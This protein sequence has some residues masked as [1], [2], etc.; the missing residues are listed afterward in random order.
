MSLKRNSLVLLLLLLLLVLGAG[1]FSYSYFLPRYIER[2]ILPDIGRRLSSS[3][4]GQVRGIGFSA[5]DFGDIVLGDSPNPAVTIGSIHAEYSVPDLLAKKMGQVT[6]NGLSLHMEVADGR[7]IMPGIDLEKLAAP[8]TSALGTEAK[9]SG[10]DLP[11]AVG[12]FQVKSGLLHI[13]YDGER[14]LLPFDLSLDS[15]DPGSGLPVYNLSLLLMPMGEEILLAGS[16]DLTGN[17]STFTLAADSLHLDR[18]AK[19]TGIDS[20]N[21]TL[22]KASIR[23]EAAIGLFP[24]AI[25]SASLAIDPDVLHFGKTPV[26]FAPAPDGSH[27]I[28][29]ELKNI[30]EQ[31][32][33]KMQGFISSPLAASLELNG[34]VTREPDNVLGSGNMII[35][36]TAAK[37]AET[38]GGPLPML[39]NNAE[40]RGDF[41]LAYN[42][43]G[44]WRAELKSPGQKQ[45]TGQPR[46]LQVRYDTV[47]LQAGM[48]AFA[49]LGHGSGGTTE[50]QVTIALPRIQA[51]YGDMEINVPGA[52]LQA[53]YTQDY[54]LGQD[55]TSSTVLRLELGSTKLQQKGLNVKADF[56]LQGK[57]ASQLR[58]NVKTQRAEG[59]ITVRN[60]EITASDSGVK[61]GA[62]AGRIPWAWPPTGREMTGELKVPAIRWKNVDLGSFAAE[63]KA[64]DMNYRLDGK[65]R[66]SLLQDFVTIVTG[67]VDMAGAS[68]VGE[69][70]LQADMTPFAAVNLGTFAPALDKAYFSGE[71]GLDSALVFAQGS[72]KGHMQAKLQNGSFDFPEKKYRINGIELSMLIPALPDLRTA[73]AQTLQFA[74]AAIGNLSFTKGK[75]LWQVESPESVF[76]EEGM[77]QWAGG[78]VFTNAV[79]FA[80]T[81]KEFVVPLFC[82]RLRLTEILQ[83]FEISNAEGEGNVSGRIPLRLGRNTIGVEDGFLYSSP[84]Q[85]GSVKVAAFALFSAGI[86][87][88]TPQFAQVDFAAEALK[89]FQYNWVKLL[90]NSE[91]DDLVLQMQMDGKPVQSLPFRYD[92]RTGLLQRIE[93]TG[94]GI[95]QPIRLD[96]NFRLP[97]NRFLGYSGKFQDIMKKMK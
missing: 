78:R 39:L 79:R 21:L 72:F 77:V 29:I 38:G 88:N 54:G 96:V 23:G 69:I 7:I 80:P 66:S 55:R 71:L 82:D 20:Q 11:F 9:S 68:Y 5:A 31:L 62:I 24:F 6:V 36:V 28:N 92:S 53:S 4:T 86:P 2:N 74:E 27:T 35:R 50:A 76:L 12:S 33:V 22:G 89:N 13:V 94:K 40:F 10:T 26:S 91:G 17:T 90:L 58:N 60:A 59:T 25:V 65:Y 15:I 49:L 41:D 8:Q 32:L 37:N 51:G 14:F 48:P 30:K 93:D 63:I 70:A 42:K 61:L 81:M 43:S 85:G 95:D 19:L 64:K 67:S 75:M 34:S 1:F 84:G 45:Q 73:P 3:L 47:S 18:F 87:K 46:S 44:T 56:S 16:I 83:Q 52:S 57:M 97:L